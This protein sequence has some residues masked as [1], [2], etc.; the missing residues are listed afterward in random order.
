MRETRWIWCIAAAAF[1]AVGGMASERSV[2]V[3]HD[4]P[5]LSSNTLAQAEHVTRQRW[6]G[7]DLEQFGEVRDRVRQGRPTG[8]ALNLWEGAEFEVL[9][10][11]TER[12][13]AGYSLSGR[14]AGVQHG[15]T[16]LVVN[17]D[18][19]VGTV[20][21]PTAIYDI[22]TVDD[23]QVLREV[24][25]ASLPPLAL[26]IVRAYPPKR[27]ASDDEPVESEEGSDDGS[28]IEVLILWTARAAKKA[29]GVAAIRALIDLGMAAANDAYARSGVHFRVSLVGAE[30]TDVWDINEDLTPSFEELADWYEEQ[31]ARLDVVVAARDRV[32][33]DLTSIVM[34]MKGDLFG[35]F[36][37]QMHE[38]SHE[39]ESLAYSF[40][41][42]DRVA[43]NTLA[44]MMGYN[45]GL[46]HDRFV[47]PKGGVFPYSHGYVNQRMADPG[48]QD[49]TCWGTIMAYLHQCRQHGHRLGMRI[50]YFSN[51]NMRYP[52]PDGDPIGVDE[53]S[54]FT[55][56]RGPA[57]AVASLNKV[58]HVVA[59]FRRSL[60]DRGG[61]TD[62]GDT[63]S[64]ATAVLL[65][66]ITRG[67]LVPED[68]D[69]FRVDVS[70][71][72]TL[73]IETTG[74]TD[75]RGELTSA[76]GNGDFGSARDDN[77]GEDGN[78]L[79]ERSVKAGSYFVAV[80]GAAGAEGPYRLQVSLDWLRH[81]YDDHG[82]SAQQATS[83]AVPSSTDGILG[84]NDI[85][86]FRIDLAE[87]ATLRVESSGNVDTHGTLSWPDGR[88]TLEDDDSGRDQN[89]RID[90]ALPAGTYSL[91]VRGF[92]PR[93]ART[94]ST[95]WIYS[96]P[97]T[98]FYTLDVRFGPDGKDDDHGDAW[99]T[100]TMAPV[101]SSTAGALEA[102][103][104]VDIFRI[105]L[106][107]LGVLRVQTTGDTDTRGRLFRESDG[108]Y[109]ELL[110]NDD[111]GESSNFLI[112][113]AL[114][115]GT[116]WLEVRGFHGATTG[117]YTLETA[118]TPGTDDHG[119]S[120]ENATPIALPSSIE[121][122]IDAPF[123][124][125]Y[126]RVVLPE[127]GTLVVD[128]SGSTYAVASLAH[129]RRAEV[130]ALSSRPIEAK[131]LLAGVYFVTVRDYT[132]LTPLG[133]ARLL[134]RDA[135][136]TLAVRFTPS[137][138]PDDHGDTAATATAVLAPS[139]TA[140]ELEEPE[141][142]DFFRFDVPRGTL[143]VWTTGTT[144]TRGE[145]YC[146]R[147]ESK[148]ADDDGGQGDNFPIE[149]AVS[150]GYCTLQVRGG[151]DETTGS[152]VLEITLD[153]LPADDHGDTP[154]T[155][156][157]VAAHSTTNGELDSALDA[158]IFRIDVPEGGVLRLETTGDTDTVAQLASEDGVLLAE[159]DN[160]GTLLNARIDRWIDAGTYF[161][162]ISGWRVVTTSGWRGATGDYSLKLTF[163]STTT[164]PNNHALPLILSAREA[165]MQ[166]S[167]VRVINYSAEAGT[168]SIRAVDD[169]GDVRGPLSL[170]L[171]AGHAGH[172]DSHDLE[173]GNPANDLPAGVG[174]GN[175][176]W[177][178]RLSTTLDIEAL[179]YVRT[180]DGF[181][182]SMHDVVPATGDSH[183]IPMFNPA[184][185]RQQ[186]SQ[187]R[188]INANAEA[189]EVTI[190]AVDDLGAEAPGGT[191]ALTIPSGEA[192]TVT[193]PQLEAGD[194]TLRGSL[195]DGSGKWRLS[196]SA[197]RP[198]VVMA[199][200]TSPEGGMTNIS[201]RPPGTTATD[202]A[203]PLL[204]AGH[205]HP[206]QGFVRVVN[207]SDTAGEVTIHATSD[208]GR[209]LG[210]LA[211]TL[212]ARYAAHFN[213]TDLEQGNATKGLLGSTG[214]SEGDWRLSFRSQLPFEAM[215]YVR[216]PDGFLATMHDTAPAVGQTHRVPIF[217]PASNRDPAS[218]LRLVNPGTEDADI[219]IAATDDTGQPAPEGTVLLTL[220]AQ[221]S[222]TITAQQLE[223]GAP[224]LNGR[225]GDGDGRWRL[226]ISANASI[227]AMNLLS[228]PDGRLANLS[229]SPTV[230]SE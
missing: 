200:Q 166:Q 133:F 190:S 43:Y 45:M 151:D 119:D 121:G 55:D 209:R 25:V 142:A 217:N 143:R 60:G 54:T 176:D 173:T 49:D 38:L 9:V 115:S 24:D 58:R 70:R 51:P 158:D 175:G 154:S 6:A 8:M 63:P 91:A 57:N 124:E 117:S 23:L 220:P 75:T 108:D 1:A 221:E 192:R 56:A 144:D 17:G 41:D 227:Q 223:E 161:I 148:D 224:N 76:E 33:A 92:S 46:Q 130:N 145:L 74:T 29:G 12:T 114:G 126:F 61:T 80:R 213:S 16:T 18:V 42:V 102:A 109:D 79:I 202:H 5:Q 59:N 68:V 171:G 104:D 64:E 40:V 122:R 207:A 31:D 228:S 150:A 198:I 82:D 226:T 37:F 180:Q 159:D 97:A 21:T 181:F 169:S 222:R 177:R 225:F 187:L 172:F 137:S 185:N 67:L 136:Y 105:E 212:G 72:G 139:S 30:Q 199:L 208:T 160:S 189:A 132:L 36:G 230:R 118:F 215:A 214:S 193:A 146:S 20:W 112:E 28:V 229:S 129:D 170:A 62:H 3:F 48:A 141:D 103:L 71:T 13:S 101:P 98:G 164:L 206:A 125:D 120:E 204:L 179:A 50:P 149:I 203:L 205:R 69:Y 27:G 156:S 131:K 85:D 195:G 95:G 44:R 165:P 174:P 77:G 35:G 210:P 152:Y 155:A 162:T 201:T 182:A 184:S 219:T 73:R 39:F 81:D 147:I 183:R 96:S 88:T 52:G 111:G 168:V 194:A 186:A 15:A 86:Y 191:V 123:D 66:S 218:E 2:A 26:P 14:L 128:I 65:S 196:V 32:G 138:P 78:F 99:A 7:V 216:A 211:L 89:F 100:A 53:S 83:V 93:P 116:Y 197:T 11:R 135:A 134:P 140:G 106:P 167:F 4:V 127:A 110:G 157:P 178:L 153:P 188:L 22:R 94:S 163:T 113:E 10:D 34:D 84:R 87:A 107:V 47:E 90:T 19:V